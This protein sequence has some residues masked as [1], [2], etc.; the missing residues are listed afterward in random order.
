M[1][2]GG[3]NTTAGE[4]MGDFFFICLCLA[5]SIHWRGRMRKVDIF[6]WSGPLIQERDHWVAKG[7]V[8]NYYGWRTGINGTVWYG[9]MFLE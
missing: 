7:C 9:G 4:C 1:G 8:N 5:I 3:L 6:D 2:G